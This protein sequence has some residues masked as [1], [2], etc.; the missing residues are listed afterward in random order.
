[1]VSHMVSTLPIQGANGTVRRVRISLPL[2]E[3]LVDGVRYFRPGDL[4]APAGDELRPMLQPRIGQAKATR[5][6]RRQ[7]SRRDWE[8]LE[9]ILGKP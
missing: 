5:S 2:I 7:G 6:N 9:H 8:Q 1:M 3:C 4:P